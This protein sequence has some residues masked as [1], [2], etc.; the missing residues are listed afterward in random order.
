MCDRIGKTEIASDL[1]PPP[2]PELRNKNNNNKK[3][4]NYFRFISRNNFKK[5]M[6]I[7][8]CIGVVISQEGN[9]TVNHDR[10]NGNVGPPLPTHPK[11]TPNKKKLSNYFNS[12]N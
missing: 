8:N 6:R 3:L 9:E 11:I 5:R 1:G 2:P 7:Q 10:K 4:L 12:N